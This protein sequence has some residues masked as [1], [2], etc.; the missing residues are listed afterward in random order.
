MKKIFFVVLSC[1]MFIAKAEAGYRESYAKLSKSARAMVDSA[2]EYFDSVSTFRS[3]FL[4]FNEVDSS[5]SEGMI[6]V[7]K[8]DKIKLE[9]TNPFKALFIKNKGIINYYDIDLDELMVLPQSINPIFDLLSKQ[10]NLKTT[11]STILSVKNDSEGNVLL[12]TEL[13]IKENRIKVLYIFDGEI[14]NLVGL[15]IDTGDVVE[16]SFFNTIINQKMDKKT[17]IFN[18]PRLFKNRKIKDK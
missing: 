10:P 1:F 13:S 4:Q 11:D 8:P 6:Y 12:S 5:M 2:N 17:F 15:S 16:L 14:E 9:Y 18:N 7:E 3:N